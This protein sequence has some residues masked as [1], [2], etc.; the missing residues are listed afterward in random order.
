MPMVLTVLEANVPQVRERALQ[1]A[2]LDAA[3]DSLPPGLVRSTLL[4]DANDP[5]LWRIQTLWE[6]REQAGMDRSPVSPPNFLDWKAESRSLR[7]M[8]AYRYWGFD[9][10]GGGPP[11]FSGGVGYNGRRFFIDADMFT[12]DASQGGIAAGVFSCL[13][14][15]TG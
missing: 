2:Y 7:D 6:S 15:P 3:R 9:L 11:V 5:T 12:E 4:R 14:K 1:N 10:S 13:R 8:A